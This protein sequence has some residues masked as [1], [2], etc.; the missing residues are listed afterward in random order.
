MPRCWCFGSPPN[1]DLDR[2]DDP[3][4]FDVDRTATAHLTFGHGPHHC[5]GAALARLE[6]EVGLG[7]LF[8]RFPTLRLAVPLD[9]VPWVY[10]VTTA[11]PAV[12]PVTWVTPPGG[13]GWR[14][15]PRPRAS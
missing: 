3:D 7:T 9:E 13:E 6:L 4:R 5:I 14:S 11:G 12:L 1:R 15:C 8:R 10:R 2:F